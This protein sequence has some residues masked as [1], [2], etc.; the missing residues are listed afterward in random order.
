MSGGQYSLVQNVR[1]DNLWGDSF[2]YDNGKAAKSSPKCI[3]DRTKR[4]MIGLRVKSTEDLAR[5]VRKCAGYMLP[6]F[7]YPAISSTNPAAF[8][9]R[10]NAGQ[11]RAGHAINDRTRV[12]HIFVHSS[13]CIYTCSESDKFYGLQHF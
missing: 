13:G 4:S 12:H 2:H 6:S 11:K 8:V 1:G 7:V 3:N 5:Q 10:H 9:V